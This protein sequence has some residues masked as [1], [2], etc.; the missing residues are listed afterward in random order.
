MAAKESTLTPQNCQNIKY[1][2]ANTMFPLTLLNIGGSKRN[3][4]L[5]YKAVRSSG[6]SIKKKE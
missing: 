1:L 4:I 2:V 3:K 5:F 6:L